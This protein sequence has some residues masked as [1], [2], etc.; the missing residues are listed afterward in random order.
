[1]PSTI[2]PLNLCQKTFL[3][4][5][6]SNGLG[7]T[8]G[9]E[10]TLAQTL[11]DKLNT[12]L[13]LPDIQ[14][15]MEGQ[16]SLAWGPAVYEN[17][18]GEKSYAD[19]VMYVAASPDQ[20][21]YVVAI[22]GTNMS[23]DYDQKTED[24]CVNKTMLWTDAFPSLKPYGVP[25]GINP[26]PVVSTGTALG[27]NALLENMK[28]PK[29]GKS[30]VD[31]LRSLSATDSKTLIFGGHSLGGALAP[32]LALA[33]FNP[34]GGPFSTGKWGHVYV[35]PVA[36]PTPG[37]KGLSQF[38][39][40]VFPPASLNLPQSHYAWNQNIWNSLD[41]IPHA[42]VVDMLQQIPTLY[43]AVW[44]G[45]QVP[46]KLTD[47]VSGAVLLSEIG[48]ALPGPYTQLPNIQVPGIFNP[49]ISVHDYDSFFAQVGFQHVIA[50]EVLFDIL[51]L[52]SEDTR[53]AFQKMFQRRRTLFQ[54]VA[55]KSVLPAAAAR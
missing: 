26:W 45:G 52:A 1:M 20:S 42:W 19:N 28:D 44:D 17:Q 38:F 23:S 27:V 29:T 8:Q 6:E 40:Q 7:A 30:L 34:S 43:P 35:L 47:E 53:S 13:A 3:L 5:Y 4:T 2:Q 24:L 31:F 55:P 15:A 49:F 25:S 51:P 36:G 39:A 9:D 10:S 33:L 16:W 48:G 41:A 21:V 14:A 32:T 18:P 11:H 22:A 54:A 12:F 37:N 46:S 50:Y